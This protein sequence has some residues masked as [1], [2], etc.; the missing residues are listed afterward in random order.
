VTSGALVT[1]FESSSARVGVSLFRASVYV[2]AFRWADT[3]SRSCPK[4]LNDLTLLEDEF[5]IRTG[6]RA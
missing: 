4:C 3:Q 1:G 6:Q 2:E 5:R